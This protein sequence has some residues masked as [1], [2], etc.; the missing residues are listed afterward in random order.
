MIQ[1][2]VCEKPIRGNAAR[3]DYN[4]T[5]QDYTYLCRPCDKHTHQVAE[6]LAPACPR[7][8]HSGR[9]VTGLPFIERCARCFLA[10]R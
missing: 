7:C 5:T 3:E 9:V 10:V 6:L 4:E 2:R 1:C 8:G